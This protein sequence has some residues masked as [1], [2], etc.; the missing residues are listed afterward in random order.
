MEVPRECGLDVEDLNAS[1]CTKPTDFS[2][3]VLSERGN[4]TQGNKI[5][6]LVSRDI[7]VNDY[8]DLQWFYIGLNNLQQGRK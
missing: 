3:K 7:F 4:Q 1:D 2:L 5:L 8:I 6:S